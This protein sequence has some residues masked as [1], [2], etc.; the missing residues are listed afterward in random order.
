LLENGA[1]YKALNL[2]LKTPLAE[3]TKEIKDACFLNKQLSSV[4]IMKDFAV[5]PSQGA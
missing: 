3:A 2:E 5:N 4:L 1:N